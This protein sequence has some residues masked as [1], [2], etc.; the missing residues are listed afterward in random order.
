VDPTADH[1]PASLPP[2]LADGLRLAL[3]EEEHGSPAG[4]ARWLAEHP[5]QAAGLARF[6]AAQHELRVLLDP[7]LPPNPGGTSVDGYELREELGRGG[8]G[9]VYRAYD[10]VLK[11]EVA[12]KRVLAGP[13]LSPAD[14]ARFRFEAEAAASLDHPHIVRIHAF[15]ETGGTPYLVMPLLTGGTLATSLKGL[16]PDRRLPAL[17]AT[18]LVRDL[19]AAVHHAHQRGLLHRD[20]KP[21]NI[22]LDADDRPH[23]AD[24]GLARPLDRT[25]SAGMAG[26]AAYM[27]PEQARGERVLTT[28][29]DI[30][31]L[32]AI[33]FELLTGAPPFGTGEFAAVLRRVA[34]E[35]APRVRGLRPDVPRD[36]EMICRRCLEKVPSDRYSSAAELADDLTHVLNDEPI[37][38]RGRGILVTVHRALGRRRET[39]AMDSWRTAFWGAAPPFFALAM[40]QA[41]VMLGAPRWVSQV[42]LGYYLIGWT[43]ILWAF[44]VV[45]RDTLNLVE[46]A[47]TVIQFGMVFA[48]VAVA[49]GQLWMH[50]GQ[51]APV[52]QPLAAVVGVGVFAHGFTYWGR[53]YLAGG[54]MIAVAALMPLVPVTYWPGVYGLTLTLL[55]VWVG[56]HLRRADRQSRAAAERWR[57]D[58][59]LPP[60]EPDRPLVPPR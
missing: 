48:A 12:L 58:L 30:H 56:A 44:L 5:D 37:G 18:E 51:V 19:A 39:L 20:L 21:S 31:A 8:M 15:G 57:I 52:F 40:I 47:S 22:L 46:R 16:G 36:L 11:R 26:T 49:A 17:R 60:P 6:L 13:F 10:P 7:G 25:V 54:L 32:G 4:L 45:R 41:A 34:D 2:D 3:S 14:R 53:L 24:F 1:T 29:V 28:A 27:A 42:A 9:V 35:V 55:Q 50:A 59:P 43:I 33:L 38:G 23:V